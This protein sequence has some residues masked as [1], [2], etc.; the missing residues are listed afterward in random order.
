MVLAAGTISRDDGGGK[1]VAAMARW[2]DRQG[3]N[4]SN[5]GGAFS[6][7]CWR[8]QRKCDA[9][10]MVTGEVTAIATEV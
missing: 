2:D 7:W 3:S 10:M 6:A 8:R 4:N 1:A 5:S 9:E